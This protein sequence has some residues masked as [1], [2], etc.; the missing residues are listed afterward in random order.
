MA[1]LLHVRRRAIS[2]AAAFVVASVVSV[3]SAFA[4]PAAAA[5]PPCLLPP[6]VGTVVDP[7][8]APACPYC[9]GNRGIDYATVDG[10]AIVAAAPGRV[11]FAG[12]VAGV[13][14][15]VVEHAA[16]FRTTYGFLSGSTVRVGDEV[17]RGSRIATSGPRFFFGLR[18]GDEYRDPG[19]ALATVVA[20]PQLVPLDG[21][22]R[23]PPRPP[24][25]MCP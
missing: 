15:L 12:S 7:F 18:D 10:S 17:A 8:R 5:R 19:P 16:G 9:A 22:D 13:R 4:G 6:V 24:R 25:V 11:T 20:R 23:P 21:H 3:G 1:P 2:W 14:Y